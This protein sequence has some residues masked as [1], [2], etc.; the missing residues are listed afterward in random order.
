MPWRAPA[1]RR[2]LWGLTLAV[3]TLAGP[4]MA[5]TGNMAERPTAVAEDR[6]GAAL[7]GQAAVLPRRAAGR[8]M[9][10]GGLFDPASVAVASDRLPLGT[11][12]RVVNRANG[13]IAM[14]RVRDRL[15][16][17]GPLLQV[18]PK[19]ATVLGIEAGAAEVEV[20]PLAVPQPDGR[21][22][23]GAGTRLAGQ[24]AVVVEPEG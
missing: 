20:A 11:T 12:A 17:Q 15:A 8:R 9:A 23:L 19:V 7:S 1:A 10:D 13:R 4:A 6:S 16:A 18:S 2:A 22:I 24:Q 3:A 5:Q 21:I 14:V